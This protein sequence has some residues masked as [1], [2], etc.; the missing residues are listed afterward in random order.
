MSIV[1]GGHQFAESRGDASTLDAYVQSNP[2]PFPYKISVDPSVTATTYTQ[3]QSV[4]YIW[5]LQLAHL[6]QLLAQLHPMTILSL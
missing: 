1:R 2:Q 3:V 4:L 6:R 5:L